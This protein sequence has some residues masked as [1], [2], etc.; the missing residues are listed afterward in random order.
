MKQ[1][2][3]GFIG[4]LMFCSFTLH[5]FYV[6]IYQ[7]KYSSSKKELQITSRIFV[8]DLNEVLY[9]K[10]HEKTQIGDKKVTNSDITLMKKY[11]LER[12]LIKV[13]DKP[14]ELN[15]LSNE[16][17]N[18]VIICYFKVKGISKIKHIEIENTVLFEVDDSQQNIIQANI[19]NKKQDLLLDSSN[20]KGM[21]KP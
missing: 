10:Y 5:K 6:S 13:N 3:L 9:K 18:N 15:Y 17:E 8:D 21:L 14:V 11:I 2:F 20:V 4:V 19:F 1:K 7:I 16:V 12:F